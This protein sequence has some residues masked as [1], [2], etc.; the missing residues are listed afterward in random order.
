MRLQRG[1]RSAAYEA[2][3]IVFFAFDLLYLN[4]RDLRRFPLRARRRLLEPI[5]DGRDGAI[6]LAEGVQAE[7]TEFYR[8]ACTHGL[9]GIIAKRPI[10][11]APGL[12]E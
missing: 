7:G 3:A 11:P 9:G 5:V 1:K 2:G 6:R 8:V 4:G 10:M 12:A